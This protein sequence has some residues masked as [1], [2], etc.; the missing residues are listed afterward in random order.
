ML[1]GEFGKGLEVMVDNFKRFVRVIVALPIIGLASGCANVAGVT[2]E[3]APAGSSSTVMW[4]DGL[5][6]ADTGEA[7][8]IKGEKR[9]ALGRQQIRDGEAK[10]REGNIRVSQAKLEYE[11]AAITHS[12]STGSE[13]QIKADALREIGVRWDAAIQEIKDGNKLIA[14]GNENTARG[15]SEVRDGRLLMET[16][17]ILMRNA[18]RSRLGQASL[19][20]P[21]L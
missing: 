18:Q 3:E 9:L 12:A 20:M 7:M 19:S 6:A 4:E 15:E 17:S 16:G 10:I 1:V 5:K 13:K 11:Q 2:S 21:T 14:K 8:L